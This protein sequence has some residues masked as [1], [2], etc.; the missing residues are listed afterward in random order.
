MYRVRRGCGEHWYAVGSLKMGVRFCHGS[1]QT[2]VCPKDKGTSGRSGD[3]TEGTTVT[4]F[5][6]GTGKL[7]CM[8]WKLESMR[9]GQLPDVAEEGHM[10]HT[11]V[12]IW[13]GA[14]LKGEQEAV[15]S[16]QYL[17]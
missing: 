10:T 9:R 16:D 2:R 12:S 11:A 5:C 4:Q 17:H 14:A 8:Y 1:D 13:A 15:A 7:Q 3:A 6:D